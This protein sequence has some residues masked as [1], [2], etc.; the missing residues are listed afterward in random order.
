MR[1]LAR[2]VVG[3]NEGATVAAVV[4]VVIG[5]TLNEFVG[6]VDADAEEGWCERGLALRAV[7]D[8]VVGLGRDDD[9]VAALGMVGG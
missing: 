6:D 2:P 5:W 7:E 3:S 1:V 9:D 8:R 4:A